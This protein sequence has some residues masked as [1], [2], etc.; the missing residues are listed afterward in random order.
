MTK[1]SFYVHDLFTWTWRHKDADEVFTTT[2]ITN[3][4]QNWNS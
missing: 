3:E 4:N 1:L 2:V